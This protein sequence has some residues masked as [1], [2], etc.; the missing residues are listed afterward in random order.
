M[1]REFGPALRAALQGDF[2]KVDAYN[3]TA[4]L[5][6][7]NNP[8]VD[9][10][11][12]EKGGDPRK[13]VKYF[14]DF[15]PAAQKNILEVAKKGVA[16]KT[17]AMPLTEKTLKNLK[18]KTPNRIINSLI[19]SGIGAGCKR[20]VVP[21]AQGGRI[22]MATADAGLVSCVTRHLNQTINQA[23]KAG[24]MGNAA[25]AK[26]LKAGRVLLKW[27][28]PIDIAVEGAFA[29]NNYLKGDTPREAFEQTIFGLFTPKTNYESLTRDRLKEI[30]GKE[31]GRY[32][33]DM[34]KLEKLNWSFKN[35]AAEE[36]DPLGTPEKIKE[37]EDAYKKFVESGLDWR[38]VEST[39]PTSPYL[40]RESETFTPP[41][42]RT[43]TSL[44]PKELYPME[45]L[46]TKP[47]G[48]LSEA[49]QRA[50]EGLQMKK[51]ENQ[52]KAMYGENWR[53]KVGESREVGRYKNV[54]PLINLPLV[55]KRA[56][57]SDERISAKEDYQMYRDWYNQPGQDVYRFTDKDLEK[58]RN[59][60][61]TD[62]LAL[63]GGASKYEKGGKVDYYDNYLPDVD[64]IDDDK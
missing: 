29:Y 45:V 32:F 7:K 12:I 48:P 52:M 57:V 46:R 60:D 40:P 19:E 63:H 2:S 55:K 5:F 51:F 22:G 62:L 33:A 49:K 58:I 28:I 31:L 14:V 34:D 20:G 56:G 35:I 10:P 38:T 26:M 39:M 53:D 23:Q 3:K 37:A 9:V 59:K 41:D 42:G 30:G 18:I 43:I 50:E 25:K 4:A 16:I 17:G 24:T 61:L 36:A 15:S 6:Q 11:F 47:G 8:G 13:T 1:D 44:G 64:K 21:K 27:G 54:R